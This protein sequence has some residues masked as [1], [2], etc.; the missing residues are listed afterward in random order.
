MTCEFH[1]KFHFIVSR[2]VRYR[3]PR[4]IQRGV[5]LKGGQVPCRTFEKKKII[6]KIILEKCPLKLFLK[7][8]QKTSLI[9]NRN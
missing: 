8:Q 3:F 6:H 2:F 1:V 4:E 9:L 7:R 5:P